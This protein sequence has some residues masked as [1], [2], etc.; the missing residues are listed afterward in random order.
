MKARV[1]GVHERAVLD[2]EI[3]WARIPLVRLG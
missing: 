1:E 2:N 3:E